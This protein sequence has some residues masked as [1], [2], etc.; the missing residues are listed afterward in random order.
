MVRSCDVDVLRPGMKTAR[1][2]RN[3]EGRIVLGK[4]IVLTAD[5]INK[6]IGENVFS[7]YIDEVEEEPEV[8]VDHSALLDQDYLEHY[9]KTFNNL[10][11]IYYKITRGGTIDMD[12]LNEILKPDNIRELCDGSLAVSQ[13]HN[14]TRTEGDYTIFH[15]VNVGILA[16]LFG[17]WLRYPAAN[18]NEIIATGML[19]EIGK[20]KVPKEIL[21]KKG[22][23]EP[24]EFAMVK[25]HVDHGY[26]ILKFS[27]L[28]KNMNILLGV[29]QHHERCDGSGYPNRTK[30]NDIGD[31]GKIL[32]FLDVYD[33]MAANRAYARRNSP[34]DI[35]E[36]IYKDTA[37]GKFDPRFSELFMHHMRMS[38]E[39]SWVG[40]T[41]GQRA[42]IVFIDPKKLT[43]QPIV[44]TMKNKFIDL[45]KV[46]D[47]KVAT[48][49]TANEV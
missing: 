7:V 29:L 8:K 6:L 30:G 21:E 48:L 5:D 10:Q 15:A 20:M 11:S 2:V 14:M 46:P 31:Y 1:E 34:F 23:L 17:I 13:I 22:K 26:N 36:V 38:F 32:S 27:P 37:S 49:L 25:K 42:R 16:G 28:Q 44:R 45:N 4:N 3:F 40:L 9:K 41:D 18:L 47:L 35:F 19:S 39:G 43:D 24:E 12:A 33:A